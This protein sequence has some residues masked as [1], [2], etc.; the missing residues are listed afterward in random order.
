MGDNPLAKRFEIADRFIAGNVVA[1]A[2]YIEEY[3]QTHPDDAESRISLDALRRA[4]LTPIP[5]EELDFNFGERWIPAAV[6]S[7]Y[8]S[9]LFDTDM[10]VRYNASADEY[11][12]RVSELSPRI[13]NQYAVRS[14][15]RLFNGVAL[16]RHAIHNTTPNITKTVTDKDGKDIKVRDPEATQLANSKIDE[17]RDGFSDWLMEQSPEFKKMLE[18]MYNRKFN[19]FV[20][21]KFDGSHQ[22]FPDLDL[23]G[24]GIKDLYPSQKDCIWMLKM[25]GG[26]IADHEV[27]GGKTLIMCVAAYEMKRLGLA[28]K[29]LI[30]GLKAN[31]HEIAQTF[32]TAYPHAKILYPGKEDF[33]PDRRVEIFNQMKNNDWDAIILSHEQFG[34]IRSRPK[35]SATSCSRNWTAW[36]KTWRSCT[37]WAAR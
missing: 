29:P 28:H 24:L 8:A 25:N 23:K 35:S 5:F 3:L 1:K 36:R 16:M 33:T 32:R 26:G 37:S 2:E 7:R 4:A 11:N 22:T 21:P 14:E 18:D 20:R 17:I 27:G 13:Y 12:I 6:Y 10:S 34:M 31:I 9:W 19:C 15:T 30:T